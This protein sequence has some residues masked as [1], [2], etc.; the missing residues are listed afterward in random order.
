MEPL[1]KTLPKSR[2]NQNL[3]V[4]STPYKDNPLIVNEQSVWEDHCE[5]SANE[6]R[7][8]SE[9]ATLYSGE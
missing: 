6:Y 2:K 7:E 5:Y 8:V 4:L 1:R 3:K 9:I